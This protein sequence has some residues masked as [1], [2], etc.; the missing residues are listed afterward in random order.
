VVSRE[1]LADAVAWLTK[2]QRLREEEDSQAEEGAVADGNMEQQHV[3]EGEL[4]LVDL[5]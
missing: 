1:V 2:R 3:G 5:T 4:G